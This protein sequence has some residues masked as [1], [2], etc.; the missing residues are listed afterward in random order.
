MA[1]TT[2][3]EMAQLLTRVA[4]GSFEPH[5]LFEDMVAEWAARHPQL[6]SAHQVYAR[7][8]VRDGVFGPISEAKKQAAGTLASAFRSLPLTQHTICGAPT[9]TGGRCGGLLY[10]N[11]ACRWVNMHR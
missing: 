1:T 5:G 4:A 10:S 3:V 6:E 9:K 2:S 11:G 8:Q 7:A